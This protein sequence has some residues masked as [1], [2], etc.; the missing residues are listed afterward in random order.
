V[1]ESDEGP[2]SW[3]ERLEDDSEML[4]DDVEGDGGRRAYNR[5]KRACTVSD[6]PGGSDES[7]VSR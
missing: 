5:I 6:V 4:V 1:L 3:V 7:S 2:L